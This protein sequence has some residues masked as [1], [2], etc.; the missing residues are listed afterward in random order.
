MRMH[1]SVNEWKSWSKTLPGSD[2]NQQFVSDNNVT[3]GGNIKKQ[4]GSSNNNHSNIDDS[5]WKCCWI[6]ITNI[7]WCEPVGN[8]FL[9]ELETDLDKENL[10]PFQT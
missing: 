9:T 3:D 6:S 5:L 10:N 7:K 4:V 1:K 8:W 2:I